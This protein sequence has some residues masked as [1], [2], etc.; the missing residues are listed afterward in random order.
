M[1]KETIIRTVDKWFDKRTKTEKTRKTRTKKP[2]KHK[3]K[4]PIPWK[5]FE[6]RIK[7]YY[8]LSKVDKKIADKNW[9]R[10][11][12]SCQKALKYHEQGLTDD[13][14]RKKMGWKKKKN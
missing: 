14:V 10:T 11:I 1:S 7:K 5:A 12:P 6:N 3:K 13:E 9:G 2:E 8:G 4:R